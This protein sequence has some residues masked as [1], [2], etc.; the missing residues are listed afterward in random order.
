MAN[1]AEDIQKH[2]RTYMVV[3]ASLAGLTVVTVA[4]SY[5]HLPTPTAIALALIVATIKAGLVALYFMHL[6]SEERAIYW[7]LGLT[8]TFFLVLM[9]MP[10]GWKENSVEVNPVWSILPP[11]GVQSHNAGHGDAGGGQAHEDEAGGQ[12]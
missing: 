9:Y 10:T 1:H 4:I 2:V 11:E 5:L 7:L 6:I 12:H 8:V 3:F